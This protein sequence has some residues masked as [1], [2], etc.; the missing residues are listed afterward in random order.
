VIIDWKMVGGVGSIIG[1]IA[2]MHGLK[3]RKWRYIHTFGV[4]LGIVAAAAPIVNR[5]RE[6][7]AE[8]LSEPDEH[9][10]TSG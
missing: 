9:D 1:G 3:T 7:R 8:M 5:A 6:L 4:A 2:V 10:P